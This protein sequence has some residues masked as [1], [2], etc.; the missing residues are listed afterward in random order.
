MLAPRC[1]R[2]ARF[3]SSGIGLATSTDGVTFTARKE[4]VILGNQTREFPH[5]YGVAGGGTILEESMPG[6]S[7]RFRMYYTLAVG[8]SPGVTVG[9]RKLCA[10][11]HS[12]D[13]IVWTNHSIVLGPSTTGAQPREDIACA[14]P[15][16]FVDAAG[17]Y[18]MV[19]ASFQLY[20][21]SSSART[22]PP[23]ATTPVCCTPPRHAGC[24]LIGA[25][26][27]MLRT[28]PTCSYSAIGSKWGFYSLAQ[29]A[30]ADG[31]SW[32]R[33]A[34]GTDD[35]LVLAPNRGNTEAWDHQMVEYAS[36][37]RGEEAGGG[38]TGLFYAGNGYGATGIGYTELG[39]ISST[40]QQ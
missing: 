6:G 7:I 30:S 28:V 36:V 8:G 2:T 38:R 33:G 9:Q 39:E 25:G 23:P 34:P 17:I 14:A 26:N 22:R 5:N 19:Y 16:V 18:R 29:A 27:P 1:Y 13:G 35:D 37:W 4:P 10:V 32:V 20:P 24:M 21:R 3:T 31:Y 40:E 12:D 15:V 11:A